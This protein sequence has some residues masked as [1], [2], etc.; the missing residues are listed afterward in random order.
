MSKKTPKTPKTPK[1]TGKPH[2]FKVWLEIEVMDKNENVLEGFYLPDG[3]AYF[4]GKNAEEQAVSFAA[5]VVLN[6]SEIDLTACTS[7]VVK[8]AREFYAKRMEKF[9]KGVMKKLDGSLL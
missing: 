3:L 6:T 8:A 2:S 9:A 5:K 4:S 7:D 1:K